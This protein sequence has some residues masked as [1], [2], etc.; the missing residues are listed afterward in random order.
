M[1]IIDTHL[2]LWDL[3][4][5]SLPWLNGEGEVLNRSYL[6]SDYMEETEKNKEYEV[7]GAVYIEVD[8]APSDR[9]RENKYAINLCRDFFSVISGA[10]LSGDLKSLEFKNYLKPYLKN[11]EVKGI[12]QV[13]HVPSAEPKTCLMP[14]FIENVRF[15]GEQGL[16]FEGCLRNEEL[17]DLFVLAESCK[18]TTII[19]DHM[20][21]VI[22]ENI[23]AEN[24]TEKQKEYRIKWEENLKKLSSLDNVYCKISGLN[25]VGKWDIETLRPSVDCALDIFGEDRVLFASNYPVCNIST[26]INPWV[27]ALKEIT[28]KRGKVFQEKL[29]YENAYKVYKL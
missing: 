1:K 24:P 27:T 4:E 8:A 17:N 20:G 5:I 13:L 10:V 2:H 29:F 12:R 6:L 15:L 23:A 25:P 26:G 16:V 28:K 9:E 7:V 21:I 22:P 14:E 3:N 18:E 19:L 11:K